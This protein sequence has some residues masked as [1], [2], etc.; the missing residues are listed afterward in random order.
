[1]SE[2]TYLLTGAM[3]CIGA[4]VLRS[5]VDRGDKV[6]A[7]DLSTD[8]VRPRLLLSEDEIA[9]IDWRQLD[10]TDTKAVADMVGEG[11]VTH[12]IHLAGLQ[13]PFC[14]ANPPLGAA[15]NVTGTVNVFEAARAHGVK[16]LTYA[17]S[18]AALGPASMYDTW[19]LPDNAQPS[20]ATLYGVYK[21]ANEESAR[22][23]AKDWG[24]G[25]VGLRPYVVYGVARDQGVTA[26]CAKAILATAAGRPF[27]IRFSG[28]VAMQHARD[29]AEIF[30][31]CADA[32]AA[33][34][35]V[36]NLRNDVVDV[37]EFVAVLKDVAPEA[38]V[39]VAEGADLP[40]PAD[41]SDA[42]LQGILG[43]VPHTPLRAAIESDLAMY[44]TLIAEGRIDMEQ[45]DG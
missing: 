20:P 3:G 45:L 33:D 2:K 32:E 10:V 25:S 21:T 35:H 7:T 6:I 5:L 19:P 12:I 34:A 36:C 30:I 15:V 44:R 27:N 37:A 39:T 40:F 4:W 1:M 8:P 9:G 38:Q 22:I 16:G 14:R 41:L 43:K 29:V 26:D 24:V 13:I 23:Y 28:P 31:G 11:G 42:G 17:S 18:L